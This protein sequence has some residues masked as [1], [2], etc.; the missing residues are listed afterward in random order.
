MAVIDA[1]DQ[2]W[3]MTGELGGSLNDVWKLD[4]K[5]LLWTWFVLP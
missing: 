5:T 4:T 1:S 2:I 3:W